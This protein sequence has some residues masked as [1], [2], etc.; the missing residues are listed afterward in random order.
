MFKVTLNK[1]HTIF[2]YFHLVH[3]LQVVLFETLKLT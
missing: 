2:L 1:I 3:T